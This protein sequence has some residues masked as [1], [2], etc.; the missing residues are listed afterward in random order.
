MTRTKFFAISGVKP[1]GSMLLQRLTAIAFASLFFLGAAAKAQEQQDDA[2][3]SQDCNVQILQGGYGYSF[4]GFSGPFAT[5]TLFFFGE[6]RLGA[7]GLVTFD[8]A[9]GLIVRDTLARSGTPAI[10]HVGAGTYSVNANCTGHASMDLTFDP[11]RNDPNSTAKVDSEHLEFDFMIVPGTHGREFSFIVTNQGITNQTLCT[12]AVP[13]CTP[14]PTLP[15]QTG[16]A[17]NVGDEACSNASLQGTYRLLS[18]GT[19]LSKVN[20]NANV[21]FRILDGAGFITDA[22]D[23]SITNGTPAPRAGRTGRYSAQPDCTATAK[24]DDGATFDGV[25]VAEGREAYWLRTGNLAITNIFYKKG[26]GRF[27][28]HSSDTAPPSDSTVDD[29]SGND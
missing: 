27:V 11:D 21:G 10:E 14:K 3:D 13:D 17:L 25:V 2:Q 9:G 20:A 4:S 28:M 18:T 29:D 12:G 8:G 7:V 5:T 16:V 1:A 23:T 15:V 24:F 26:P 19:N 6:G 22:E